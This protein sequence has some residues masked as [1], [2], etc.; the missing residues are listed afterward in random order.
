MFS[1]R[2][3]G[4]LLKL[5]NR[6]G[7]VLDFST[8][9]F[10]AFTMDSVGVPL[11]KKYQLSKGKSLISFI[12]DANDSDSFKLLSDLMKYYETEYPQFESETQEGDEF[13]ITGQGNYRKTY[14]KAK[15]ILSNNRPVDG[16]SL[17]AESVEASFS[18]E[19]MSQQIRLMIESQE[20]YPAEAI[21]KAKELIESC[22]RTILNNLSIAIDKDWS[23]QNLVNQTFEEL[24]VMPKS[25]NP[26]SPVAGSLKRLYGSL[27]GM[28][29]PLAEIRNTYGTGHGREA[30]FQGLDARHAKL[31]VGISATLVTFLWNTYKAKTEGNSHIKK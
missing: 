12:D 5:F 13:G 15:S 26:K 17:L 4:C 8:P 27:K 9:D 30:N 14:L 19:Y 3:K 20:N 2:E 7:Y 18:T 10:D 6:S 31:I 23:F 29:Q 16:N 28:V 11:C 25:V 24:D 22:C 1:E 21:G